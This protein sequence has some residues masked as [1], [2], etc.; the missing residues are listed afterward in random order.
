[1]L[2]EVRPG[3]GG[4]DAE[5]FAKTLFD[6]AVD[7]ARL[8]GHVVSDIRQTSKWSSFQVTGTQN[9]LGAFVGT[10]RV[11]HIPAGSSARHTSTATLAV[12]DSK[13][14]FAH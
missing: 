9:V 1:M 11:Q 10:H 2:I 7:I 4:K 12:L 8:A 6:T 14:T 5:E 3:E 13:P